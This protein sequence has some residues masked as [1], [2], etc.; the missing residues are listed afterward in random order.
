[1]NN[2]LKGYLAPAI[3]SL[4]VAVEQGFGLSSDVNDWE[5]GDNI[6]GGV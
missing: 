5:Q 3:E 4:A 1:M 6:Q 2:E